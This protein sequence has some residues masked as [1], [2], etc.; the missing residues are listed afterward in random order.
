MKEGILPASAN[1]MWQWDA[2]D[3]EWHIEVSTLLAGGFPEAQTE[4]VS[5]VTGAALVWTSLI[6][7]R[8]LDSGRQEMGEVQHWTAQ[9]IKIYN[10]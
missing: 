6:P 3:K 5:P 9:G 8:Q 10:D 1:P 2:K 4:F 7:W